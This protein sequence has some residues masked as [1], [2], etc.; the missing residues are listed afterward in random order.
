MLT[1]RSAAPWPAVVTSRVA[2]YSWRRTGATILA[3]AL[4][5]RDGEQEREQDLD[6][7][8][9]TRSSCSSSL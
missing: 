1:V 6:A 2:R 7:G 8:L 4:L 5:E 9:R 3:E